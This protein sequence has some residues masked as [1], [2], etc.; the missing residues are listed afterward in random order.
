MCFLEDLPDVPLERQ[1]EF[2]IDLM[3]GVAPIAKAL[4]RLTPP[5]M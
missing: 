1:V 2:R 4:Y 5:D 3:P